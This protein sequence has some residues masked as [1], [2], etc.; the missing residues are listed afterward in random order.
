MFRSAAV[1]AFVALG[2]IA[3]SIASAA[4]ELSTSNR[5][6]D[7]REVAAGERAYSGGFE[8]GRW[9]ANGW[10]ISGEMGGVWAPPLKLV[11]GVWFGVNGRWAG[12][13]TRFTSG[14]GYTRFTLPS[15]AGLKLERT[16][17][18]SDS[19]RAALFG[20]KLRNTSNRA[21][22]VTVK[23]DAHSELMGQFPWGFKGL[24]PNASE[25]LPDHG[26]FTRGALQFTDDGA[27]TGS[28]V[29]HYA[30]LVGSNRAP[31]SGKAAPTGGAYRGPQGAH[32]CQD[33]DTSAP[34]VCD[35]GPF[36]HG[37]GGQLRYRVTVP[38]HGAR[39]V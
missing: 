11:D 34:S 15:L 30:A 27:L 31:I 19:R 26:A 2:L 35:D 13:A 10:H 12:K 37:T 1:A 18:A 5:L 36:G 38:A 25:N 20:L 32:A 33:G 4:D 21:R 23:V 22:R 28:P 7:R 6:Q 16:D 39:T 8:D 9:Y 24:V 3:P 29:H 17:Y 14:Q